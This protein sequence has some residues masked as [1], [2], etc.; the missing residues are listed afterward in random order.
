L[1][2]QVSCGFF[3]EEEK[4]SKRPKAAGD[5]IEA[6]CTRCREVTNHIVVALVEGRVARVQCNICDGIHN[7][8]PPAEP[9]TVTPRPAVVKPAPAAKA[10]RAT[11][12][13]T[14]AAER[15]EWET[16]TRNA[17]TGN[18]VPYAMDSSFR[19]GDL[20]RHPSFGLGTVKTLVP[21]GKV[22]ILFE[23]GVKLLRCR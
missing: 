13:A 10:P 4:M 14:Q 2:P 7:Y 1:K 20:V 17:E 11:A 21:P 16:A 23:A 8:Y 19:V 22:A 6:R 12:R 18:V 5:H 15:E 9:R 3:F